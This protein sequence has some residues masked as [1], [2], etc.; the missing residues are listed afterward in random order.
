MNSILMASAGLSAAAMAAGF[1]VVADR[2]QMPYVEN[3]AAPAR[4]VQV[5]RLERPVLANLVAPSVAMVPASIG[6]AVL[7]TSMGFVAINEG[8]E[9]RPLPRPIR[10]T[11]SANGEPI[12]GA[13]FRP[14]V[15]DGRTS[16]NLP[17]ID[18][19]GIAL[20]GVYR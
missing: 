2:A 15:A 11:S 10:I 8:R 20:I 16:A 1:S 3:N 12:A 5:E 18:F 14:A 19:T 9:A 17:E 6:A 7:P 13:A 4:A